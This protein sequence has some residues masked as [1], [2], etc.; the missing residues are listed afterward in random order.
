M[1]FS[2]G[3]R[4]VDSLAVLF[5]DGWLH[6]PTTGR[7][8]PAEHY[9]QTCFG[10][11][12]LRVGAKR[13]DSKL[14][15][16]GRTA[17]ETYWNTDVD[18]RGHGEFN[19]FALLEAH[20]DAREG[21]Y[22][23]PWDASELEENVW[24]DAGFTTGHGNNWLLL[25]A[26]CRLELPSSTDRPDVYTRSLLRLARRWLSED[27][28]FADQPRLGIAPAETP[29]TYHA[30]LTYLANRLAE[31]LPS[32]EA[33]AD[34]SLRGLAAATLPT[35]ELCYFGRSEGSLFGYAAAI[36]AV[37]AAAVRR[38]EP[39]SP[40][41]QTLRRRLCR[42]VY[43][44]FDLEKPR[45][46]PNPDSTPIDS[47]VFDT[48]YTSFAAMLLTEKPGPDTPDDEPESSHQSVVERQPLASIGLSIYESGGTAVA[49]STRGQMKYTS[50]T[51]DPRY[52]GGVPLAF[53]HDGTS[54]IP[55]YCR[56]MLEAD[57][58]PFLPTAVVR[59]DAYA[60]ISWAVERDNSPGN[61]ADIVLDGAFHAVPDVSLDTL[62]DCDDAESGSWRQLGRFAFLHL[63][64]DRLR[65][66]QQKIDVAVTRS[67]AYNAEHELLCLLTT[68]ENHQS[69]VL[70]LLPASYTYS[71][72][73]PDVAS[74]WH[75]HQSDEETVH[76]EGHLMSG[77]CVR[78][79]AVEIE[80]RFHS[81]VLYDP[82][83]VV[84][85]GT[86]DVDP[87][88]RQVLRTIVNGSPIEF[89]HE[90]STSRV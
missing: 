21:R 3:E 59:G 33:Y 29:L 61:R 26:L 55:G 24:F 31:T 43:A 73:F 79:D 22:T 47:Y 27:G 39:L 44:E 89:A 63:V 35:G 38:T 64:R 57:G 23:V 87:G 90:C 36:A 34:R 76:V 71:S 82:A 53:S 81:A 74:H 14:Q 78:F 20:R 13:V 69:N 11:A 7:R 75:S 49:S 58:L 66:Q 70:E 45:C 68:V 62:D 37:N 67:V 17:H 80:E 52:S 46:R 10:T 85:K 65:K 50:G 28:V 72:S 19:S 6:E 1:P 25:Q 83:G 32:W 9:A 5:Q 18:V 84:A 77:V 48:V 88:G 56:S 16:I 8:T 4:L 86:H 30:K 54:V 41:Y 2:L 40:R 60:P 42:Y 12:A 15:R 51:A